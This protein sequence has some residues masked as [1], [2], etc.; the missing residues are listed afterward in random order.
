MPSPEHCHPPA[1]LQE[2]GCAVQLCGMA[3]QLDPT[4]SKALLRRSRAHTG[5]HDYAA[6]AAD[7][8]RLRSQ[9]GETA[10][11]DQGQLWLLQQQQQQQQGHRAGS[12]VAAA[13]E[14]AAQQAALERVRQ[15]D[16]RKEQAVFARMFERGSLEGGAS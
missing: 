7:L 8:D 4:S 9:L 13:A 11:A 5:R 12:D 10:A 1:P 3:L 2:Y 15:A 6:A 14:V 16:R